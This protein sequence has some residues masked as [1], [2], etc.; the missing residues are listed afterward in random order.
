MNKKHKQNLY[1]ANVNLNLMEQNIIQVKSRIT[2]NV[3]V[4]AKSEKTCS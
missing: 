4:S 1:F 2:I 3:N